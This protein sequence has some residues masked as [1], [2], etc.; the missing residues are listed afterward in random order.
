MNAS[1]ADIENMDLAYAPPFSTAIHPFSHTVNILLNKISGAFETI[2]PFEYKT[3]RP[4][5]YK[6]IDAS[7]SPSIPGASYIDLTKV[8]GPVDGYALNDKL[9]LVCAK[10][11][12]AYLL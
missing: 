6:V 12:R 5:G 3:N 10:G 9:L 4:E 8:S 2:T 11:K 7:M 1:L